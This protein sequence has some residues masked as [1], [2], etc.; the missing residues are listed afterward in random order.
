LNLLDVARAAAWSAAAYQHSTF[1]QGACHGL[2][3][4]DGGQVVLAFRGTTDATDWLADLSFVPKWTDMGYVHAGFFDALWDVWPAVLGQLIRA[5]TDRVLITGHSLGGA[6][7]CLAARLLHERNWPV[8]CVTFGQPRVGDQHYTSTYPAPL[9]RVVNEGDPV[10]WV[11]GRLLPLL[12]LKP[13]LYTHAGEVLLLDQ[14]GVQSDRMSRRDWL[15]S[16]LPGSLKRRINNH[17]LRE[18]HRRIELALPSLTKK[19]A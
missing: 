2:V 13:A 4:R 7:A 16:W 15:A 12:C 11:P 14:D 5:N 8:K 18:Y 1:G 10:P 3:S 6:L 19:A 17:L 9:L